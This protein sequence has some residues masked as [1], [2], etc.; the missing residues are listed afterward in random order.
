MRVII[1]AA[2]AC[3]ALTGCGS[4]AEPAES[5]VPAP[6]STR[7]SEVTAAVP[8]EV[9]GDD[10]GTVFTPRPDL[11]SDHPTTFESWSDA[12]NDKIAVHFTTGTPECYGADATVT[13]TDTT[14]T[15]ALRTG[16][17][18]EAQD[19]MCILIAVFGTLEVQ[20]QAPVGD[21]DV[22]NG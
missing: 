16:I 5:A 3:V 15:V 9:P 18:P 4:G 2:A 20:L 11:V 12:G 6:A 13:E 14:V 7:V 10:F 22:R 21:R 8:S 1:L 17:L 19:K